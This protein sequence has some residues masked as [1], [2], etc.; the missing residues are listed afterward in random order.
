MSTHAESCWCSIYKVDSFTVCVFVACMCIYTHVRFW[1][2]I[3]LHLFVDLCLLLT[4]V[5][6]ELTDPTVVMADDQRY[7]YQQH[8]KIVNERHLY[9]SLLELHLISVLVKQIQSF[10]DPVA[11][12]A[13]VKCFL[14]QIT[15]EMLPS[16]VSCRNTL[17][18]PAAKDWA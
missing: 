1:D 9:I 14:V 7:S 16:V 18:V 8:F 17:A 2:C 4:G 10:S 11:V 12:V 13:G 5:G 15:S 6:E 3:C